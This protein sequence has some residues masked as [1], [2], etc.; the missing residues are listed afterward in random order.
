MAAEPGSE[1]EADVDD[2]DPEPKAWVR[3]PRRRAKRRGRQNEA[4]RSLNARARGRNTEAAV[5]AA[6]AQG[7]DQDVIDDACI[8]GVTLEPGARAVPDREVRASGGAVRERWRLAAEAELKDSFQRLNAVSETT[9]E[10]LARAGGEARSTADE[11][12]L[13][14]QTRRR[15]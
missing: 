2:V 9:P 6:A 13:D 11:K 1:P 7:I 15:V 10:E 3:N 4:R 14:G 8:E 12:R 5:R